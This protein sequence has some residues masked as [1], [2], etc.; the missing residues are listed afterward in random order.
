[1]I[2][3]K[4][5]EP[6]AVKVHLPESVAVHVRSCVEVV[7]KRVDVETYNG[8]YVIVPS[9]IHETTLPTKDKLLL[10]NVTV[11]KVPY[12]ETSNTYGSTAYIAD[13]A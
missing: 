6:S 4:V 9:A 5:V 2:R 8:S 1:M 7:E 13:E 11:K 12:Y 3:V 10:D